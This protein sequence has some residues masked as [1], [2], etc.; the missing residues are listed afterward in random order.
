MSDSRLKDFLPFHRPY[1]GD[2]EIAEVVDTLKSG[3]LTMG[4]KTVRFEE[5]FAQVAGVRH[6]VAVSSCTA[7]L[8]IAMVAGELGEGDEVITSPYTFPSTISSI[9]QAGARPVLVDTLEDSPNMNPALVARSCN[10]AT[11]VI[12]PIHIAGVPC[13]MAAI[14]E[15]A[16]NCG[17]WVL[18][19]AAHA[20][21]TEYRGAPV[22]GLGRVSAYSL[23]AGKN[24]TTGEGGVLAT[25]DEELADAAR[26]IRLHGISRDAW[27]RYSAEGSWYYEVSRQGFK[28]NMTD[29]NAAIGLHQLDRLQGFQERR[30]E[31][32]RLYTELL[33]GLPGIITPAPCTEGVS[34]WHLYIM[35][36]KPAELRCSRNDFIDMLKADNIG[37]SVHFIPAHYHPWFQEKLGLSRDSFKNASNLF[38]TSISLPFFPKMTDDDVAAVAN[39]VRRIAGEQ[40][41]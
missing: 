34:A 14:G 8:H 4:P 16:E 21:G 11:R 5:K 24:I 40:R 23:Y 1:L 29:I 10:D 36:L 31:L 9:L 7:A 41:A 6:A 13:D 17:A 30:V 33:E 19:D 25:D 32:A 27:K 37:T 2:E 3:W 18:Q 12:L 39:S 28:Y 22:G 15:L 35:R 20:L 38:E 26:M